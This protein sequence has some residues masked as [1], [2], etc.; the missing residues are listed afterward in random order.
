MTAF[1]D[2]PE[3]FEARF[4]EGYTLSTLGNNNRRIQTTFEQSVATLAP[5]DQ[6]CA[7]QTIAK[8]L[9][10]TAQQ[11]VVRAL[12]GMQEI[13]CAQ[14]NW[15]GKSL[16]TQLLVHSNDLDLITLAPDYSV[17]EAIDTASDLLTLNRMDLLQEVIE[18]NELEWLHN[19]MANTYNLQEFFKTAQDLGQ[20]DRLYHILRNQFSFRWTASALDGSMEQVQT[21][22]NDPDFQV[23]AKTF[24][25]DYFAGLYH[26]QINTYN[27]YIHMKTHNLFDAFGV[28]PSL[29][30]VRTFATVLWDPPQQCTSSYKPHYAWASQ[31]A[32]DMAAG[33][34]RAEFFEMFGKLIEKRIFDISDHIGANSY[35]TPNQLSDQYFNTHFADFF[36]QYIWDPSTAKHVLQSTSWF[37]NIEAFRQSAPLQAARQADVL[38]THVQGECGTISQGRKI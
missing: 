10:S 14:W 4:Q 13:T 20:W 6:L 24:D 15:E 22:L 11:E 33:P 23:W 18:R 31:I 19:D 16:G 2:T 37:L 34:Q 28:E 29:V 36:N 5:E 25:F 35:F 32:N 12:L 26:E 30:A 27:A 9:K 1:I 21:L 38:N 3:Q 7:V 17:F 8:W